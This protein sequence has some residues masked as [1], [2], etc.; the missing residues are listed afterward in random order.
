M[1]SSNLPW[2][3]SSWA[4]RQAMY[5]PRF[6]SVQPRLLRRRVQAPTRQPV[7]HRPAGKPSR[8]RRPPRMRAPPVGPARGRWPHSRGRGPRRPRDVQ[9]SPRSAPAGVAHRRARTARAVLGATVRAPARQPAMPAWVPR[10]PGQAGLS[11]GPSSPGRPRRSEHARVPPGCSRQP[12]PA[13]RPCRRGSPSPPMPV[14][15]R[16]DRRHESRRSGWP[17]P[18]SP[19]PGRSPPSRPSPRMP[20][21]AT[22]DL[23][24]PLRGRP[25]RSLMQ[26]RYRRA[27]G[28]LPASPTRSGWY[29]S[30]SAIPRACLGGSRR[31]GLG[32]QQ[33]G[34]CGT[35]LAALR[36]HACRRRTGVG[37]LAHPRPRASGGVVELRAIAARRARGGAPGWPRTLASRS[38]ARL[39]SQSAKRS[40]RSAR[41][42]LVSRS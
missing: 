10:R 30:R 12:R 22:V 16:L 8:Q 40:W 4:V 37:R 26:G 42:V 1:A 3:T 39:S 41:S 17:R 7:D 38:P 21:S 23:G 34:L 11:A 6:G 9:A 35:G 28:L 31:Q 29:R 19:R 20:R 33:Q 13:V 27:G 18:R 14:P 24:R 25:R 32:S 36:G 5:A 2:A 15:A